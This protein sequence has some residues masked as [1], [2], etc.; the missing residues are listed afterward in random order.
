MNSILNEIRIYVGTYKKYNEGNLF[1][2]WLTLSNYDDIE[3]FYA[4]CKLLHQDEKDPELMFQDWECPEIFDGF[5]GE[6]HLEESIFEIA[7]L[8][9]EMSDD[10]MEIIE[11]YMYLTGMPLNEQT[12][13]KAQEQYIGYFSTETD[14]AEYYVEQTGLLQN[15]PDE[16][17][18]YFDYEAYA[19]DLDFMEHNNHYF[20]NY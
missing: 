1:G 9:E 3:A 10:D 17:A 12:I 13:E 5:I 18:T 11:N 2:K 20:Y 16:V 7:S 19:R 6:C 14:F 4:D 8:L 15:I